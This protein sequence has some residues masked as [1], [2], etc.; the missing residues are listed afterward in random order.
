M[1]RPGRGLGPQP[2]RNDRRLADGFRRRDRLRTGEFAVAA[3]YAD[4]E[5]AGA[6]RRGRQ[7]RLESFFEQLLADFLEGRPLGSP[8]LGHGQS[9][10]LEAVLIREVCDV[11]QRERPFPKIA[12]EHCSRRGGQLR[13]GSVPLSPHGVRLIG[14]VEPFDNRS[15][16]PTPVGRIRC[17]VVGIAAGMIVAPPRPAQ[18]R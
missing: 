13:E 9:D 8:R 16:L 12:G 1:P 18:V 11:R 5:V 2:E 15:A 6:R 3:E 7:D 10:S 4:D 14:E 17:L